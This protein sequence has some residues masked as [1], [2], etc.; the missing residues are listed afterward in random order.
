[1]ILGIS[2]SRCRVFVLNALTEDDITAIIRRTKIKVP[3]KALDW[4]AS[5]ANGDA[6]IA[7]TA[8]ENCQ[9]LYG[10][11]TLE[12]LKKAFEQIFIRFDKK[13]DEPL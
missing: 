5:L 3:P 8:I 13:G 6:R 1:M 9:R 2:L 11:I 10:S 7:I 12:N 4:L